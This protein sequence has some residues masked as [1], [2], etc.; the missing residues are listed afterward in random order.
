MNALLFAYFFINHVE[1]HFHTLPRASLRAWLHMSVL[2][3]SVHARMREKRDDL[4]P[5]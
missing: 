4:R 3:E 1:L 2:R 5:A